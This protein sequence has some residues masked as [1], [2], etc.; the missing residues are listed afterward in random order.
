MPRGRCPGKG[1]RFIHALCVLFHDVVA[2]CPAE[3][4][5]FMG[6]MSKSA[7]WLGQISLYNSMLVHIWGAARGNAAQCELKPV[8]K[9]T[10]LVCGP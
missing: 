2:A 7:Y 5:T 9:D 8:I 1:S 3:W 10:A 6:G 4:E